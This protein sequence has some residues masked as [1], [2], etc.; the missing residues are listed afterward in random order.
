MSS[1]YWFDKSNNSWIKAEDSEQIEKEYN[2][3]LN[4]TRSGQRVYHCFGDRGSACINFDSMATYCGSGRCLLSHVKNKL[5]P[6]HMT[7]KLQRE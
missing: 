1:W 7:Y 6:D 5:S 3:H 2:S 4:N